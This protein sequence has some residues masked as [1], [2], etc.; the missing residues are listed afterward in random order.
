MADID[1]LDRCIAGLLR[2]QRI[3]WQLLADQSTTADESR[4]ARSQLRNT[5]R[6]LRNLLE[7][8]S[9]RDR[10]VRRGVVNEGVEL[11]HAPAA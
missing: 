1:D 8:R 10:F 11:W 5:S 9:Q 4:A 2:L 3:S 7:M 6:D